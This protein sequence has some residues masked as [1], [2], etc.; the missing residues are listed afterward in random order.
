MSAP[1]RS[2]RSTWADR[3]ADAGLDTCFANPGTSE[4]Q[5]VSCAVR[6]IVLGGAAG[7][8]QI[9]LG[10]AC[11]P[12]FQEGIVDAMTVGLMVFACVFGSALFGLYLSTKV[13]AHHL[14]EDSKEVMKL[15]LGIIGTLAALVL[16]LLLAS[17]KSSFDA[18]GSGINQIAA[19]LV[20]L[21]RALARYGP[22]TQDARDLLRNAVAAVLQRVWPEEALQVAN[23]DTLEAAAGLEAVEGSVWD[24]SPGTDAQ[25]GLQSRA[26]SILG[27]LAQARVLNLQ[28]YKTTLPMPL[29]MVLVGWFTII[30]AFLSMIAPRNALVMAIMFACAL[31]VSAAIVLILELDSPYQGMIRLSSA[32]VRNALALLGR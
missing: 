21:D 29:L 10:H 1:Q 4:M 7:G 16:G 8:H 13:A 5:L 23:I 15:A 27:D 2:G 24:L 31:S 12:Q 20:L 17:A 26:L 19:D 9:A 30:F 14:S 18:K 3:D 22:E 28:R 25:R 6:V 11:S 32:P